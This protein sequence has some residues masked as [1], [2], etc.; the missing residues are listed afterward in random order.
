[1]QRISWDEYFI[2]IAKLS[3][4]RSPCSRLQ[5]GCVIVKDNRMISMGYNGF[6]SGCPHQSIVVDDHEQA[7]IHA[8]MNAITDAAKRGVSLSGSVAYVTHYPCLN[9]F[10]AL[11][12][13]GIRRIVYDKDYNNN[14]TVDR[15]NHDDVVEIEKFS[16]LR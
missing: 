15:L 6:L 11:A 3:S 12:S 9:C 4:V 8:E 14:P 13:S 10:K 7:T 2:E 16:A 1:M 5:V